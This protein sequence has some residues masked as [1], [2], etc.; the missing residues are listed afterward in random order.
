[1]KKS[2]NHPNAPNAFC[3]WFYRRTSVFVVAVVLLFRAAPAAYGGF[4]PTGWIG[5]TA[6]CLCHS[7]NNVGSKLRLRPTTTAHGNTRSLTH[8]ARPGIKPASSWILVRFISAVPHRELWK[9]QCFLSSLSSAGS[10]E[11]ISKWM[12]KWR[13]KWVPGGEGHRLGF[14]LPP[15]SASW[16]NWRCGVVFFCLHHR[17][18]KRWFFFCTWLH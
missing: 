2:I 16:R 8:W 15:F 17:K 11:V 12:I 7:H 3:L 4:Q 10:W 5:A 14:L 18:G 6:A 13:I 1:M 9:D